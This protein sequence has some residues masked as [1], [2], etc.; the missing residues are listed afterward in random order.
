MIEEV[1]IYPKGSKKDLLYRLEKIEHK[2]EC[3][4]RYYSESLRPLKAM[5]HK[6]QTELQKLEQ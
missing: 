1:Q 2:M 4:K 6:I 3:E 5:K